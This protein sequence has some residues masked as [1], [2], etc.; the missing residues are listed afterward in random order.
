MEKFILY[1]S[2]NMFV[3]TSLWVKMTCKKNKSMLV[4]SYFHFITDKSFCAEL[5]KVSLFYDVVNKIFLCLSTV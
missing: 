1:K 3:V 5:K 4:T 2:Q